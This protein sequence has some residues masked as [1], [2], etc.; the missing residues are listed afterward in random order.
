M[1][2]RWLNSA[3]FNRMTTDKLHILILSSW[4]PN[5]KHPFLG[6]FVQRHAKLLASK[7]A[8]TV[9]NTESSDEL[10]EQSLEQN[11]DGGFQEIRIRHPRGKGLIERRKFQ[12]KALKSGLNSIADVQ[13]VIGHIIL[14]K[15]L[16]F[17]QAKK[18]FNCPLI[19]VEHGSFFRPEIKACRSWVERLV[20]RKTRRHINEVIA[21]SSFL[22]KDMATDFPNHE[23]RIIGNHIDETLFNYST[24]NNAGVVNFLHVSTMDE[25]TKNPEGILCAC[26]GLK[27][28]TSDFLLT[29]VCDEDVYQWKLLANQ[30][31]LADQ[32]RFVG[33]LQWNELVPYYKEADAFVLFSEYES[34]SIVLAE[35]WA[36]GTPTITT[37]VG[38]ASNMP[39]NMGVI[40]PRGDKK[41]LTAAMLDFIQHKRGSFDNKAIADYGKQFSGAEIL[42][43]WSSII[44]K[45]VE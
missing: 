17:V 27:A 19:Y 26:K 44:E 41:A 16:Q 10:E 25:R 3:A 13:L 31:E 4:Y 1:K 43:Q 22:K 9:I 21:V 45:H 12:E 37:A 34:F 36:T 38:I 20:L 24:K 11:S 35:A 32:I 7:Y 6:N 33:P 29:I 18:H 42:A 5:E 2:K 40:I 14:P 15:G 30:F 28:E 39:E 23:I 8:V